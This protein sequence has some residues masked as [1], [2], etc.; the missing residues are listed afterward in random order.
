MKRIATVAVV[1]LLLLVGGAFWA[2]RQVTSQKFLQESLLPRLSEQAGT[3]ITV[4]DFEFS[5]FG[6]SRLRGVEA[7][8]WLKADAVDVSFDVSRLKGRDIV[9]NSISATNLY[10]EIERGKDGVRPAGFEKE[11]AKETEPAQAGN[12]FDFL[13]EDVALE[14]AEI[15]YRD[16]VAGR[17]YR[18][19]KVKAAAATL[20]GGEQGD[21]SASGLMAINGD[22]IDAS[23]AVSLNGKAV[24]R[25][26]FV[27]ADASGKL[28]VDNLHY[29]SDGVS[30]K[31]GFIDAKLVAVMPLKGQ[32]K[33]SGA[34]AGVKNVSP[35]DVAADLKVAQ[36]DSNYAVSGSVK[37]PILTAKAATLKQVNLEGQML[38]FSPLEGTAIVNAAVSEVENF[39]NFDVTADLNLSEAETLRIDGS[40]DV[41]RVSYKQVE[42]TEL[43]SGIEWHPDRFDTGEQ[44]FSAKLDGKPIL[45]NLTY[46]TLSSA[47]DVGFSLSDYPFDKA[48][49]LLVENKR[50]VGGTISAADVKI[51]GGPQGVRDGRIK[52]QLVDVSLDRELGNVKPFNILF[53]PFLA[54]GELADVLALGLIPS[55]ISDVLS[56]ARGHV[57]NAQALKINQGDI[58]VVINAGAYDIQEAT[59]EMA[60]LPTLWMPG[61]I[62][63]NEDLRLNAK[64]GILSYKIPMPIR[65]SLSTPYPDVPKF[66]VELV[67]EIGL[68]PLNTIKSAGTIVGSAGR[69]VG[70][71]AKSLDPTG[72]IDAIIPSGDDDEQDADKQDSD[73]QDNEKTATQPK[74]QSPS[75]R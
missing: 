5:L 12:S 28:R 59:F 73:E 52:L 35:F 22:D 27:P 41:P 8:K 66:A 40:F 21:I 29:K 63:A 20:V 30:V 67:K 43:D 26:N 51:G 65:G 46:N 13:V 1:V 34:I 48:Y 36:K 45:G 9:I 58:D 39:S 16:K 38:S 64:L 24:F 3:A 33:A 53:A 42:L 69:T 11:K 47:Y 74:A 55:G 70:Y 4:A 18:A 2:Y 17:T 14:N 7:G 37:V 6:S 61:K 32:G 68:S 15:V 71:V 50:D 54:L 75:P 56:T 49:S 57:K 72:L 44:G 62:E 31:N 60:T 19:S 10:L 25:E 23:G